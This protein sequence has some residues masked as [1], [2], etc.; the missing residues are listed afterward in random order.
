MCCF[1][2]TSQ[3]LRED[4]KLHVVLT[5]GKLRQYCEEDIVQPVDQTP[6]VIEGSKKTYIARVLVY[7]PGQTMGKLQMAHSWELRYE[8]GQFVG[9][10][11]RD[12]QVRFY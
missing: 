1:V 4:G 8:A 5:E 11:D 12:L 9:S 3:P 6:A 7:V 10:V 2:F